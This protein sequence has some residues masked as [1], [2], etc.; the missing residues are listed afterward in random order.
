MRAISLIVSF[1]LAS[2]RRP[3]EGRFCCRSE[4]WFAS[5]WSVFFVL[6]MSGR[7]EP[8]SLP[9]SAAKSRDETDINPQRRC[10]IP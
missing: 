4:S 10:R 2:V 9:A 3:P 5:S 6:F 7:I 1:C 8:A